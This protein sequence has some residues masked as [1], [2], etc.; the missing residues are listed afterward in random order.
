MIDLNEQVK[1]FRREMEEAWPTPTPADTIRYVYQELGEA[2]SMAMKCGYQDKEYSRSTTYEEM[3]ARRLLEIECGHVLIMFITY[4]NQLGISLVS[5]LH[6]GMIDLFLK[7]VDK[8]P[9]MDL[10]SAADIVDEVLL[11]KEEPLIN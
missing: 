1:R 5:A 3:A 10:E 2:D 11:W 6:C 7:Q 4:L 9:E 8:H